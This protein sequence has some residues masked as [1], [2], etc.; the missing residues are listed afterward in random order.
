MSGFTNM[1]LRTK[2]SGSSLRQEKIV[3]SCRME[4][5]ENEI[6]P[7]FCN[8]FFFWINGKE[9]KD[10]VQIHP[11][12]Y[13]RKWSS[14]NGHT[15]KMKTLISEPVKCGD[16]FHN[17]KEDTWWICTESDCIN[18]IHY[19]SKL[20]EC[21]YCLKFQNKDLNILQYMC[22]NQNSTQYN[23]GIKE[24]KTMVLTSAQHMLT[25]P[26]VKDIM[27]LP[28]D[29]RFFLTYNYENSPYVYKLTQNDM[30]SNKGLCK[31]T[32]TQTEKNETDNTELGICDYIKPNIGESPISLQSKIT[33]K[34]N[35]TI[36]IGSNSKSF[37][38]SFINSSGN[39]IKSIGNWEIK[40]AFVDKLTTIIN[41]NTIGIKV[42][43]EYI[44]LLG[45][46]FEL[47][48]TNQDKTIVSNLIVYIISEI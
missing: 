28:Y 33:Y 38:G 22:L 20:T 35:A 9:P 27:E 10:D 13:D 36:K 17:T 48:F 25:L 2:Q 46:S 11:R 16:T 31:V 30:T 5:L 21:N 7:S 6:D 37:T 43:D 39:E 12:L 3:D 26:L 1:K 41:G 42:K 40:C 15:M 32:V 45:Q 24:S 14:A 23:S 34:G 8:T 19:I 4:V 29:K 47:C 18:D 44:E